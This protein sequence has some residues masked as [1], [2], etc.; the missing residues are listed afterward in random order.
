MRLR[1]VVKIFSRDSK[2]KPCEKK[3]GTVSVCVCV[4]NPPPPPMRA[5]VIFESKKSDPTHFQHK[6]KNCKRKEMNPKD[7]KVV[8]LRAELKKRGLDHKGRKAE[9]VER[10]EEALENEL[11]DG[12]DEEEVSIPAEE[13][14]AEKTPAEETPAAE[15][16]PVEEEKKVSA[17]T[18]EQEAK[19]EDDKEE[20]AKKEEKKPELT[21]AQ[22]K[23]IAR[24]KRF[25]MPIPDFTKKKNDNNK[26]KRKRN[27]K[28][29]KNED[30][31][32]R[33]KREFEEK[34]KQ[35]AMR[36]QTKISAE[37]QEKRR[38]RAERFGI[39][40]RGAQS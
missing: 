3:T 39:P 37:E 29:N 17:E 19:V 22:L 7:L 11:L 10:L 20:D 31:K 13:T 14:P 27:K 32:K 38:K 36:F 2:V 33:Q 18:T 23:M 24:A 6:T 26:K 16:A 4:G 35:R 34:K 15:E 1:G 5:N 9:L 8:E 30:Q 40:F 21:E 28:K 25:G 12:D